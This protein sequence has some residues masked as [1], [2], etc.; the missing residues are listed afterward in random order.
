MYIA[1]AI[2]LAIISIAIHELGHAFAMR[3]MGIRI[4]E[5]SLFGFGPR[6]LSFRF[7][8]FFPGS[9]VT[10]RSIPLGA[11]VEARE[12][13]YRRFKRNS[14]F[15]EEA[16]ISGAGPVANLWF[17]AFLI[18]AAIV[19]RALEGE[20][21]L[22]IHWVVLSFGFVLSV[23]FLFF[24]VREWVSKALPILGVLVLVAFLSWIPNPGNLYAEVGGPVMI[25][26][27]FSGV[28]SLRDAL[29]W[30]GLVSLDLALLNALPL[31]PLDGGGVTSS[32]L[33][34]K[35][36]APGFYNGIFQFVGTALLLVLIGLVLFNDS[37]RIL[38]SIW[39]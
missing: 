23:P 27:I 18:S 30:G 26:Q 33:L 35:L 29:F 11:F 17:G 16:Y 8:R 13:S 21:L 6:I 5:I 25:V 22:E 32:F 37:R 28:S 1:L 20:T 4:K 14:S 10:L 9:E 24:K 34:K 38:S 31:G 19:T 2:L 39:F 7:E 36:K 15:A 12:S 3:R